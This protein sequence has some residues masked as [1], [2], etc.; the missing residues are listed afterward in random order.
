MTEVPKKDINIKSEHPKN[1]TSTG[2]EFL[3]AEVNNLREKVIKSIKE[4]DL[5]SAKLLRR[6]IAQ[7]LDGYKENR[8]MSSKAIDAFLENWE[9]LIPSEG[10]VDRSKEKSESVSEE[11][12]S[13]VELERSKEGEPKKDNSEV[14]LDLSKEQAVEKDVEDEKI[15]KNSAMNI[16][17][18]FFLSK[19]KD[20]IKT[21]KLRESLGVSKK[22]EEWPD[23]LKDLMN[24]Y[25]NDK[26][27]YMQSS[28]RNRKQ[29]IFKDMPEMSDIDDIDI[30][31]A[32]EVNKIMDEE[33]FSAKIFNEVELAQQEEVQS[34]RV[35]AL[36]VKEKNLFMKGVEWY[37]KR[38]IISKVVF[39]TAVV[40]G[41][42]A[43]S[44][45][46]AGAAA[47][48][49]GIY[50]G[51]R[52]VRGLV[53]ALAGGF[54][55]KMAGK[56][57]ERTVEKVEKE[58]KKG[59]E[60]S[61]DVRVLDKMEELSQKRVSK[62]ES[63]KKK[64]L[65]AKAL[66]AL[67]SGMIAGRATAGLLDPGF[68]GGI[69]KTV[70]DS[71]ETKTP[72]LVGGQGDVI[73]EYTQPAGGGESISEQSQTGVLDMQTVEIEKE[74]VSQA[75]E[76]II[77]NA[78]ASGSI[79]HTVKSGDSVWSIIED[80]LERQGLFEGMEEGQR[81]YLIDTFKDKITSMSP[82]ELKEIGISSGDPSVL[83][84][85]DTL[86]LTSVLGDSEALPEAIL[87]AE[88][89]SDSQIES[90][91]AN[92][93]KIAEWAT[94]H[95]NES[96]TSSR[97]DSILSGSGA[98][99]GVITPEVLSIVND[100]MQKKINNIYEHGF[101]FFKGSQI[102]EWTGNS[103]DGIVGVK[104]MKVE[105]IFKGD[106][107]EPFGG[108]LDAAQ[109]NNRK[110]LLEFLNELKVEVSPIDG[111]T[112]EEYIRRAL[113]IQ[114]IETQTS[115]EIS[116]DVSGNVYVEAKETVDEP[117]MEG[118]TEKEGQVQF[119]ET[120]I[121]ETN[122]LLDEYYDKYG[123]RHNYGAFKEKVMAVINDDKRIVQ[124]IESG[125]KN[126]KLLITG[127]MSPEEFAKAVV[128]NAEKQ[129]NLTTT[130]EQMDSAFDEMSKS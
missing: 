17:R 19:Y 95:P 96:I 32:Q 72:S 129:T 125:D 118:L 33:Y 47:G 65:I 24:E 78:G 84:V 4:G 116:A 117:Q 98:N 103:A 70:E 18:D 104:D 59:F 51:Q 130:Q 43:G 62:I 29:E 23:E 35:E 36:D 92:N 71:L 105:N 27:S 127:N 50:A 28:Y 25:R 44:G 110:Q 120:K 61:F 119:L 31:K 74:D 15:D 2:E 40:T 56:I 124:K 126:A 11:I 6:D 112:T 102:E 67:S 97:I 46:F 68:F 83:K 121:T 128:E 45:V 66:V 90:I 53:G 86:D 60:K 13:N 122:K 64:V 34:A 1:N 91:E 111:E 12:S 109:E 39:S 41:A 100:V 77:E 55:G 108:G 93:A 123:D 81:T 85:G 114:I 37:S 106:F 49:T 101:L 8:A 7:R 73:Q 113:A 52:V 3:V 14:I 79:E 30:K 107:G 75:G 57:G 21:R 87:G 63:T 89:L 26:I 48:A 99:A 5:E 22:E 69:T 88:T 9:D 80:K 42:L 58:T 82:D 94:T 76:R 115:E 16:S 10:T 20:Y 54:F 38:S